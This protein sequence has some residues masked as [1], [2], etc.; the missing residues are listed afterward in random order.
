VTLDGQFQ[1]SIVDNQT[2]EAFGC[3]ASAAPDAAATG[4]ASCT[5]NAV[6][7]PPK[8]LPGPFAATTSNAALTIADVLSGL[9]LCGQ[10]NAVFLDNATALSATACT[11][12]P[13]VSITTLCNASRFA[14]TG[15]ICDLITQPWCRMPPALGDRPPELDDVQH[16]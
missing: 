16:A 3:E 14:C 8:A 12:A 2:V 15:D 13:V 5:L 7:A 6:P 4:I 1:G 10:A 11:S 9:Q